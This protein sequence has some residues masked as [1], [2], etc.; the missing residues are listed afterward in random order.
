MCSL[1]IE[2]VLLLENVFSYQAARDI[3]ATLSK[4]KNIIFVPGSAAGGAC[5][6]CSLT[7]ECVLLL[8]TVFSYYRMCSLVYVC[9]CVRARVISAIECLHLLENVFSYYRMCSLTVEGVLLS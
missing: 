5:R 9:V 7:I 3:T 6:M 8:E 2:S 4:S 1:K